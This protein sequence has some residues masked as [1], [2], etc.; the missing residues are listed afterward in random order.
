MRDAIK[1]AGRAAGLHV[2]RQVIGYVA[3][4]VALGGT[5]Y[6]GSK[7]GSDNIGGR[8]LRPVVDRRGDTL[9]LPPGNQAQVRATCKRGEVALEALNAHGGIGVATIVEKQPLIAKKGRLKGFEL[10]V[11]NRSAELAVFTPE[12]A[13]LRR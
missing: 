1:Q 6:A 7:G 10:F 8:D 12:V 11:D 13:C 2:R 5:A 3:L 4:A 9:D